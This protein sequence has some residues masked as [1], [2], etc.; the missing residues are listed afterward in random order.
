MLWE[1]TFRRHFQPISKTTNPIPKKSMIKLNE[2]FNNFNLMK[3]DPV[4]NQNQ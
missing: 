4:Q 2:S 3:I 1:L